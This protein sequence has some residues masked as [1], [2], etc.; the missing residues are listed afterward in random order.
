MSKTSATGLTRYV[1]NSLET[2]QAKPHCQILPSYYKTIT[3]LREYVKNKISSDGN[4][5][6]FY[7]R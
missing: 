7:K 5:L 2:Y 3:A 1:Q 6:D 4:P